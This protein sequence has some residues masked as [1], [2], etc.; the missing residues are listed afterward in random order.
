MLNEMPDNP[1][2]YMGKMDFVWWHGVVEAT[3]DPLKLGR[4]RVRVYG[5]HSEDKLLIPTE[6]LFP[7]LN[8]IKHNH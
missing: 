2:D 6:S 7:H 4:C 3:N 5:F 8:I 1:N